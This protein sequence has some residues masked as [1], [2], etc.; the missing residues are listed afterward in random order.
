MWL[1]I[2]DWMSRL[3]HYENNGEEIA[4]I[5]LNIDAIETCKDIPECTTPKEI[6]S[7]LKA[8]DYMKTC[9]AYILNGWLSTGVEVKP[10]IQ[11]Y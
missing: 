6:R 4:I 2:A 7:A 1:Y 9:T 3:N 10:E 8:D 11:P 5:K